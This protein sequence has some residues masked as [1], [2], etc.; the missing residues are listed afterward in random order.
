[1]ASPAENGQTK[2]S[3]DPDFYKRTPADRML[4]NDQI[5]DIT[6]SW[7]NLVDPG[8]AATLELMVLDLDRVTRSESLFSHERTQKH[9]TNL[10]RKYKKPCKKAALLLTYHRMLANNTLRE[11][12]ILRKA[13]IKKGELVLR[14]VPRR[15]APHTH[16]CK[17]QN[18]PRACW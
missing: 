17:L 18:R 5:E 15:Y 8:D 12:P 6:K 1:M 11:N 16:T 13:L 9:L 3:T 7:R 14:V 4:Y 2:A 10:R